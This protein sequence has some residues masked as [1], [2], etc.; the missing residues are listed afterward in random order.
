M[1]NT[2]SKTRHNSLW[3]ITQGQRTRYSFALVAMGLTSVFA[4]AAPLVGM[5]ALDVVVYR[6]FSL[7]TNVLV[8][9]TRELSGSD[10][11]AWY[12]WLSAAAGVVLT[13][14]AGVFSFLKSRWA[15]IASEALAQRLRDALFGHLHRLPA[16]FLTPPTVAI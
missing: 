8:S 11:F 6:D 1:N 10:S 7:G 3:V 16:D 12:L 14:L 9:L 4:I 5:Y 2:V 13:L 15:A